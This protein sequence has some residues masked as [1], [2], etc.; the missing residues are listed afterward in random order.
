MADGG[1]R[2]IIKPQDAG[3]YAGRGAGTIFAEKETGGEAYI[4]LA[5]GKRGRS[6]QILSEVAAIFG[7]QLTAR[8][9]GGITPE[10]LRQFASGI[11]GRP[12]RWGA[13]NGDTFDTDCSGAQSTLANFITGGT[14]RFGTGDEASALLSRGFQMG[15]P[16]KG[17]SA[18]WIGW[19][20]GGDG[21]GHTAGTIVDP[22]NGDV[23]VEMGGR[24]G[25]GQFGGMAAGASMFP[26]RAWIALAGGD[27]PDGTGTF[28]AGS[29]V[30]TAANRVTTARHSTAAAQ[31][32]L[33]TAQAELDQLTAQ[34]ASAKKL[35]A[36][37][38]KRDKAQ[39]SLTNA[40][41]RQAAAEE[42]LTAAKEKAA[43]GRGDGT[44]ELGQ[45]FGQSLVSG[46]MQSL[47]LDG[48]LFSD[49]LSWPNVQSLMAGI[50]WGGNV[51]KNIIGGGPGSGPGGG[52]DLSAGGG[53][54]GA[55][56]H[57][58]T[59]GAPPGPSTVIN[60]TINARDIGTNRPME[61]H[62]RNQNQAIRK[63]GIGK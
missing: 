21:G 5:A 10:A 50:N 16:P 36:A 58:M 29:A 49:P 35:A 23:N 12:Y 47:G 26:Q 2:W 63:V 24:A 8:E 31:T 22:F 40:Q 13:G 38:K 28:S 44:G 46:I 34:G 3:L 11:A 19:R 9:D 60:N 48:T 42:K 15:D 51:L 37:E 45:N 57:G 6:T 1:L 56:A 53:G 18:Y 61:M 52:L 62:M 32:R 7:M 54:L 27:N 4:P 17:I 20:P 25:G 41:Q 55:I 14:G 39:E 30:T 59:G 43:N 33:D